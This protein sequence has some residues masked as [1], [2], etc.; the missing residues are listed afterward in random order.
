MSFARVYGGAAVMASC[1]AVAAPAQTPAAPATT[2]ETGAL[3]GLTADGVAVFRGIPYA[4]PPVGDLRWRAPR[5]AAAWAGPRD[6]TKFANDCPQTWMP[7]DAA[8]SGQPMSEDCLYTNVWTPKPGKQGANKKVGGLPVMVWIHGGGFVNGSGASPPYDGLRLAKHGV[9][10]VNFTYRIGR[11]GFFA[12]PALTKEANGAPTGNWGLMDQIAALNWV[13]RNIAAFGGDPAQVTIFGESAGGASVNRLMA[14][15]LARGLFVRGIASSGGGRDKWPD[16]A[17]AEAKGVAF[18]KSVGAG[19][20]VAS[21]R[22][23]PTDIVRGKIGLLNNEEATYS[24]GITDGQIVT[25]SVDAIF[26]AGKEARIPYIVGAN[27]DELGFLPA[28]FKG[29]A[30]AGII[31]PLGDVSAVRTAYGASFDDRIAGDVVFIEPSIALARRHA[32]NGNPTWVYRFGYVPEAKRAE[33][34]GAPH[35]SDIN[36]VFDTLDALKP[37]PSAAD[38]AAA[39]LVSTYWSDFAR[40]G[41][42]NRKGAPRWDRYTARMPV[43]LHIGNSETATRPAADAGLDALAK[44]RDGEK[45]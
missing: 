22:A 6:A 35:A 20:D 10:V 12:H 41:D 2:I 16:L 30:T 38:R 9:V 29:P 24:G 43:A 45:K 23:I 17:T 37:A 15:P 44:L 4:A 25:D 7:S 28:P 5:P 26:A 39:A 42:P 40:T 13:K 14:S 33:L 31:K 18:A 36:Y 21:L 34:K 11:L 27:S 3:Q 1:L 8:I 19:E 32:A